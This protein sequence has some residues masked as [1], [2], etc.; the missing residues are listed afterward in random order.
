M[1]RRVSSDIVSYR[2]QRAHN[3]PQGWV[4]DTR[5]CRASRLYYATHS[6]SKEIVKSSL[7]RLCVE[8][9]ALRDV[10]FFRCLFERLSSTSSLLSSV[11][12]SADVEVAPRYLLASSGIVS[13]PRMKYLIAWSR[14]F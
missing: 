6:Q 5:A 10:F 12:I 11:G 4:L 13:L 9:C 3:R 7:R 2:I 14:C 8:V 1:A